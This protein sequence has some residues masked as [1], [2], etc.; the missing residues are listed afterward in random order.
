V[1]VDSAGVIP[2]TREP[3][4]SSTRIYPWTQAMKP[5]LTSRSELRWA[6]VAIPAVFIA[7][8][9]L[10]TVCMELSRLVPESVRAVLHL[11]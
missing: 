2:K 5:L 1:G 10:T 9:L 6:A 4:F 8:W 11:L 3:F 7:H